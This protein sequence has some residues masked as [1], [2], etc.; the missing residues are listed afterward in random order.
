MRFSENDMRVQLD[1]GHGMWASPGLRGHNRSANNV[2][3]TGKLF[4]LGLKRHRGLE[5]R[6]IMLDI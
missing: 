4:D 1:V 5:P 3:R 2:G 6:S